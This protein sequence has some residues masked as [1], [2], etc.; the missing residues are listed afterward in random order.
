MKN[1]D[2]VLFFPIFKTISPILVTVA[3]LLIFQEALTTKEI[4]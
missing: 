4:I 3:G 2:S 1:I